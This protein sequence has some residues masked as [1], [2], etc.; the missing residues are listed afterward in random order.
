MA[1]FRND[2]DNLIDFQ[3]V[4]TTPDDQRL[5]IYTPTNIAVARTQ[6]LEATARWASGTW[7][8]AAG[9]TY[10]NAR[11]LEDNLP[12]NRR[13]TNSGRLRATKTWDVLRGLR[14]DVTALYTGSA[15]IVADATSGELEVVGE[16]G[17]FLQWNVG[18][19]LGV[20]QALSLNAG[21]DNLFNQL[22]ENWT[23]LIER[24]FWIG[25]STQWKASGGGAQ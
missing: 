12:L 20:F 3:Q 19:Q 10:L 15:P 23:G 11:N 2:I 18:L 7:V 9:Y 1:G 17:A 24:R 4:G 8:L 21:V 14:A 16:Q 25:F 13:A 6:G 5:L 22:P